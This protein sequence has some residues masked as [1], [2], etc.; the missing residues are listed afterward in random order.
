VQRCSRTPRTP[1]VASSTSMGSGNP[2]QAT[3]V[4]TAEGKSDSLTEGANQAGT[5]RD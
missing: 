5:D 1:A 3:S 2:Q 4:A